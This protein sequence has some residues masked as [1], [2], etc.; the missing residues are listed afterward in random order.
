M[1]GLW[2]NRLSEHVR[3]ERTGLDAIDP[4]VGSAETDKIR[5]ERQEVRY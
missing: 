3:L 1:P 2:V 5:L 4:D